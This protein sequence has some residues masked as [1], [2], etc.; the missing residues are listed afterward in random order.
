MAKS[1][2]LTGASG[3]I[4]RY[5]TE[6]L[7]ENGCEVFVLQHHDK[8][9]ERKGVRVIQADIC[10]QCLPDIVLDGV[11]KCDYVIH[12]AADTNITGNDKT[13]MTNCVG[14]YYM[15]KLAKELQAKC[16]LFLSS[17]PVIGE[18]KE[19]PITENHSVSPKTLYHIT[20]YAGEMIVANECSREMNTLIYRISSP[21]GLGMNPGNYLS[22]LL[23][24][25]IANEEIELY[26]Q[27]MRI[28]NYIDVRDIARAVFCGIDSGRSGL[29]LIAGNEGISNRELAF[30]CGRITGASSEIIW[31]RRPD[32]E[33]SNRWIISNEKARYELGFSPEYTISDTVKWI[34]KKNKEM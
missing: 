4:G 28:Q 8:V 2:L 18:P 21:V 26:G 14:T 27:G 29:Y 20:K 13:L 22:F 16:F 33:E 25:C 9:K 11:R 12:L 15:A 23:K 19:L 5:V 10:S 34:C 30:L 32:F 6:C 3:F 1:V 7:V 31:G 24:K 17:I